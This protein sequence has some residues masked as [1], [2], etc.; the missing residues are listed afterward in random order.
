MTPVGL[1]A[2]SRAGWSADRRVDI[3]H[4]RALLNQYL[5]RDIPEELADWIQSLSGL[6]VPHKTPAGV[7]TWFMVT[8]AEAA[9]TD[10]EWLKHYEAYAKTVLVPV[11]VAYA[12]NYDM[13]V[14]ESHTI[15]LTHETTIC[16]LERPFE[17]ALCS[18]IEGRDWNVLRSGEPPWR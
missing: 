2:L 18:L 6:T 7:S 16:L 11:G 17:A 8:L 10:P 14:N 3:A 9:A 13:F 15:V 4:E 1:G 5:E 12:R